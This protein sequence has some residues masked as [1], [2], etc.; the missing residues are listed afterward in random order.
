MKKNLRVIMVLALMIFVA[1]CSKSDQS[2]QQGD[3]NQ[4]ASA[5]LA[6]MKG[7]SQPIAEQPALL[8]TVG[9]SADVA[10]VKAM[11]DNIGIKYTMNN[12]AKKG[13]LGDAKTLVLAIGGSSK[14]LGAAGID[15]AAELVRVKGLIEDAVSKNLTIIALHIGGE[16]RRG[17]LSDQFIEPSFAHA[18][19]AIVVAKGDADNKM[20]NLAAQK[21][22]PI[23]V[24][25]TM[26]DTIG[27]LK[28][29]FK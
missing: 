26:T 27:H 16:A 29:A 28:A 1:G 8:T 22:I 3:Q 25:E 4:S 12:M 9:Q 23:D 6:E 21:N 5:G 2:G 7:L 24:I 18:N 17:E 20:K 14:G 10:M 13:E 15:S 19:Y 11:L